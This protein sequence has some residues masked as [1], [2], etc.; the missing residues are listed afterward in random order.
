[1]SSSSQPVQKICQK[2]KRL[3]KQH[4][5]IRILL[6]TDA[7]QAL[8]KIPVDVQEL[9]VDFLTIVGHKV[10]SFLFSEPRLFCNTVKMLLTGFYSSPVLWASD[11]CF[12]CEQSWNRNTSVSNAVWRR[13]GEELQTRVNYRVCFKQ[14]LKS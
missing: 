5:R 1:M 11:W 8:G 10:R 2:V 9:G 7:A 4:E 6:H 13:T 14:Q 3:N 12:V